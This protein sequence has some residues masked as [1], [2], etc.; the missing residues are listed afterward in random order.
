MTSRCPYILLLALLPIITLAQRLPGDYLAEF[1]CIELLLPGDRLYF[2]ILQL[3]MS[4]LE[5][6]PVGYRLRG[7]AMAWRMKEW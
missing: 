2:S 6:D 4:A 7:C 5:D 1:D 3:D